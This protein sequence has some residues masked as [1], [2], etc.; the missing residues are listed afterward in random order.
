MASLKHTHSGTIAAPI[1]DVFRLLTDPKRIPEWLPSCTEVAAPGP[2]LTKGMRFTMAIA[3]NRGPR[4][5]V[6]EVIEY[7]P[8][9]IFGWAEQGPR[10]NAKTFYRLKFNGSSTGIS[11]QYLTT[12]S[13]LLGRL[14]AAL[15]TRR[16]T[17]RLFERSIQNLQM[18]L[19]R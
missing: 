8:P 19:M 10:R 3:A 18:S 16:Q 17:A 7:A 12:P 11:V 5:V 4:E 15:L 13:G 14:R 6:A 9:T 2:S 1:D